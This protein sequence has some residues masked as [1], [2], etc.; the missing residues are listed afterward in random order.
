[1]P[2][3]RRAKKA[4]K[5]PAT[6][7]RK[8]SPAKTAPTSK[9]AK[10][11][12]PIEEE[13]DEEV[14]EEET[15]VAEEEEEAEEEAVSSKTDI[16]KQLRAADASKSK[17]KK[18]L[19][20]KNIPNADSYQVLD[21]YDAML[22]QTNIGANNNKF[23]VIQALTQAS[24]YYTW[25]R[26]GRVGESGN[27]QMFGPFASSDKAIQQFKSKFKDKTKN[28]WD[29][30]S[31]FKKVAGKYDLID[32]AGDGDDE[33]DQEKAPT[34]KS[35]TVEGK[36]GTVYAASKLDNATQ[37]LIRLIF[38]T[39]MFKDALKTYD[40]DVKKMPLGKLS[41]SQIA[42]GFEILEELEAVMENKKKG[43]YDEISSR[44]YTAIPHDFGR[45]RPQPINTREGL[46]KKYDMLAVLADIELAQSM[47]KDK[48]DEGAT[49]KKV[50]DAKPHPYDVNYG[51]LKCSLDHVDVESEE[52][53]IIE[54]FTVNTQGYRKCK[55]MDVWRVGR[56][57][58]EERFSA[59]DK[60]DNRKLLWHGT[61]VAVVVAILKSGLRIMP[62]SGGR[63]G[64]GIYFASENGKSSGY[65]GT[66][67]DVGK[68]IGIMFLNEVALGKEHSIT[69]DDSSLKKPPANFDSV[70]ARGQTEP[71]P[72]EDT[73]ITIDGKKVTVPAGK[74]V[75]TTYTSSSFAQSEYLVYK[76]N[77]CRIRY[78]LK[79][80]F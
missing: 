10:K 2:P 66:T 55:I 3:K 76:E 75:R 34:S 7:K 29:N 21:D 57:G 40:I 50:E 45:A 49:K 63:V 79:M 27:S 70:V 52:F 41:K 5:A 11:T 65:V 62:H 71:D 56:E 17:P 23:Y 39:D 32:V 67:N 28:G 9:R 33:D 58:D 78:L 60:V 43:T 35:T 36:D 26:W 77:Q 44:F 30:R 53:K 22:N 18:H 61:S 68:Q 20:D 4:T 12:I 48:G 31:D 46:Q 6:T 24:K 25:T 14:V 8:A 37:S 54:K 73:S 80:Q 59:H 19:P 1:M 38:D 64:K 47:Q 74:P 51:L 15:T 69:V 72:K 13:E 42:K 16:I